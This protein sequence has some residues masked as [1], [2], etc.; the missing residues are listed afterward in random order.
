MTNPEQD[1]TLSQD[2]AQLAGRAKKATWI[3]FAILTI[4]VLALTGITAWQNTR[5]IAVNQQQNATI[6]ALH[7]AQL[8]NCALANRTRM[9]EVN[10]WNGLIALAARNPQPHQTAA[11]KTQA[12]QETKAFLSFVGTTFAPVDCQ[13]LYP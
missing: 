12:A 6:A 11:E 2:V 5:Q 8:A 4:A 3:I 1:R 10:L 13:K 7:Q 9:D